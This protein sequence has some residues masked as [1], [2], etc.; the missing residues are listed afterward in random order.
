[1]SLLE[2]RY[3]EERVV[4]GLLT[5][6]DKLLSGIEIKLLKLSPGRLKHHEWSPSLDTAGLCSLPPAGGVAGSSLVP[7]PPPPHLG[8]DQGRITARKHGLSTLYFLISY[9]Q[10]R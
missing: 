7:Y 2:S 9:S 10:S 4:A 6:H 5:D 1:M 8:L 3:R